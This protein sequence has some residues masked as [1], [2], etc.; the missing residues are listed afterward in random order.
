[1]Q[2]YTYPQVPRYEPSDNR[3]R[4]KI[5]KRRLGIID[6]AV[7]RRRYQFGMRFGQVLEHRRGGFVFGSED[8]A[9]FIR[10]KRSQ[11][12]PVGT[13]CVIAVGTITYSFGR[14]PRPKL[15]LMGYGSDGKGVVTCRRN[16]HLLFGR[17]LEKWLLLLP[18]AMYVATLVVIAWQAI[19][20]RYAFRAHVS[21]LNRVLEG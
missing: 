8:K 9:V 17:P 14:K 3:V 11:A 16:W 19:L 20:A 12:P 18:A 5:G 4:K 15:V 13:E 21:Q 10:S 2:D 1:M 7:A 6:K